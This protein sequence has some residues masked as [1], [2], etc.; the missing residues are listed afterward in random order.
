VG[1]SKEDRLNK[2]NTSNTSNAV[3][4]DYFQYASSVFDIR[5]MVRIKN[6]PLTSQAV[7]IPWFYW[8][9]K[10]VVWYGAAVAFALAELD[11]AT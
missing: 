1:T 7:N 8:H 4:L 3:R 11:D 6:N 10:E 9:I 5:H 2:V